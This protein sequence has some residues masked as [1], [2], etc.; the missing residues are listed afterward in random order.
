MTAHHVETLLKRRAVVLC[1]LTLAQVMR[2]HPV[3]IVRHRENGY[4]AR[5][6]DARSL[7]EGIVWAALDGDVD[8]A[9]LRREVVDRYSEDVVARQYIDIYKTMI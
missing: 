3:D 2:H 9:A 8:R 1:R 6:R 4:L 7:A 5:W